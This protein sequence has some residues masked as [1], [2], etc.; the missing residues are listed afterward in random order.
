MRLRQLLVLV[1]AVLAF[2]AT[3][4][5]TQA[6]QPGEDG[7]KVWVCHSTSSETNEFVLVHIDVKGWERGH[8]VQH[9]LDFEGVGVADPTIDACYDGGPTDPPL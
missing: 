4:L 6:T 9:L 5:P 7:H 8:D 1:A 3:I 2:S